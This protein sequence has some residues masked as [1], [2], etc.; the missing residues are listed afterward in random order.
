MA[1]IASV[2]RETARKVLGESFGRGT[3]DKETWNEVVK[4]NIQRKKLKK[5]LY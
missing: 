2:V 5:R 1:A 4:E 3:E